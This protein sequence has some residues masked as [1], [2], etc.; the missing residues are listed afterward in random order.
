[1]NRSTSVSFVAMIAVTFSLVTISLVAPAIAQ[2]H[3]TGS[4]EMI[5]DVKHPAVVDRPVIPADAS[6]WAGTMLIVIGA[7]FLMAATVGPI[8][9]AEMPEAGPVSHGHHEPV[10]HDAHGG[11]HVEPPDHH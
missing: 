5:R 11:H 3:A 2:N 4:P 8:V 1:M 7:M 6:A 10:G 9:R